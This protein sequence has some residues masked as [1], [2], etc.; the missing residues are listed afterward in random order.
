MNKDIER[1]IQERIKS[2]YTSD[3]PKQDTFLLILSP[4][5]LYISELMMID[6]AKAEKE[7]I[8]ALTSL[9]MIACNDFDHVYMI[10]HQIERIIK[11]GE[12]DLNENDNR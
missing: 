8:R 12:K 2:K 3:M 5:T 6:K 1:M 7:L 4:F 11:H 9:L 10:I